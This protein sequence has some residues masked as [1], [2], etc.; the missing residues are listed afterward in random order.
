[1]SIY[2][3]VLMS[4]LA[5]PMEGRIFFLFSFFFS[6]KDPTEMVQL[7]GLLWQAACYRTM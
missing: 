1:M 3:H 6:F 2:V 4:L 5:G 7:P